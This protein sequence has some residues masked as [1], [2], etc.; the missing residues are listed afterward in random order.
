MLRYVCG[1]QKLLVIGFK[2]IVG[3]KCR[4]DCRVWSDDRSGLEG[5]KPDRE[6]PV[7]LRHFITADEEFLRCGS[8]ANVEIGGH[9]VKCVA[10]GKLLRWRIYG[11]NQ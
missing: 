11:K 5:R 4:P 7:H 8:L 3:G 2:W 1:Y 10:S 6:P 9:I